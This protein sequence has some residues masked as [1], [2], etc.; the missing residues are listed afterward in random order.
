MIVLNTVVTSTNILIPELSEMMGR[1]IV[2]TIE[3]DIDKFEKYKQAKSNF[4]TLSNEIEID[5]DSINKMREV[6]KI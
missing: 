3:E 4:L 5:E 2:I 6:S 1:N